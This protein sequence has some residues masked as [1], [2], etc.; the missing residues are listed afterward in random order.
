MILS[1]PFIVLSTA[2]GESPCSYDS[3][4]G[5]ES[6]LLSG[7]NAYREQQGLSSLSISEPLNRLARLHSQSM[8]KKKELNHDHFIERYAE[9]KRSLCAENVGWNAH[10]PS[11]QLEQ[12]ITSPGH[13]R[14][15]LTRELKRAG[16]AKVGNYVTFFACN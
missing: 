3:S 8:C 1:M 12:W 5:Y 13:K 11:I 4:Q 10:S 6:S 15:V 7:I 9:S 14:N 16:I 2:Y